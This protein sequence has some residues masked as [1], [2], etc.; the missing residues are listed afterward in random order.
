[1]GRVEL[2]GHL[3]DHAHGLSLEPLELRLGVRQRRPV[4]LFE[5]LD[6]GGVPR[7]LSLGSRRLGAAAAARPAAGAAS[8]AAGRHHHHGGP[9][10]F[11]LGHG[12]IAASLQ[13]KHEEYEQRERKHQQ[14]ELEHGLH[15]FYTTEKKNAHSSVRTENS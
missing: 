14:Q 1:M 15:F 11:G 5:P 9:G 10:V 3:V 8:P 12:A 4:P 6:L 2:V 7:F 13:R